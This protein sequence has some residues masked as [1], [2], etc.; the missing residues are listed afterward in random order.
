LGI[1]APGTGLGEAYLTWDGDR[2]RPHASEGGH[3]DFAPRDEREIELLRYLLRQHEHVS[4]ERV[5]SG[6]GIPNLYAFLRDAGHAAEPSW[7]A[8]RLAAQQDP[9]PAIIAAAMDPQ[10]SCELCVETVELFACIL[11]A[12]A[13]NLALKMLATGGVFIGGGIPPRILPF[14]EQDYFLENFRDKGRMGKLLVDV[15]IHVILN[16]KAALFGAAC[17][18]LQQD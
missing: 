2:Y 14:L 7:L 17:A 16:H 12:E 6:I 5:C 18:G 13:G 3:C 8:A 9:T 4:Y 10:E 15:P 11:G 1:V